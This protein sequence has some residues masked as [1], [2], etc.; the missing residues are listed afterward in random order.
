MQR[1]SLGNAWNNRV[2]RLKLGRMIII[3]ASVSAVFFPAFAQAP[4]PAAASGECLLLTV[5]GKVEIARKGEATWSPGQT[6]Q[7]LQLGDRLRTGLRSRATVR[8]SDLSV[9]RVKEVTTI[10]IQPP[11]KSADK[12]Q[13]ELK[14]GATYLFSRE[15]PTEI[16]FRTPVASGAIRGTEFNLAVGED[17]ATVVSLLNGEVELANAQGSATLKSGEQV[18]VEPGR[19]PVKTPLLN[20]LNV[21]Q[22]VLYYPAVVAPEDFGLSAQ[23]QADLKQPLRDYRGGDLLAALNHYPENRTPASDAERGFLAALLL[24]VGNVQEAEAAIQQLPADAAVAR[25]LKEVVAA[26]QHRALITLSAPATASE[27]MARSYYYQSRAELNEALAAA[28][29]AVT[30]SPDFGAAH[31]RL[32]DLEFSFGRTDAALQAL[33]RGLA[34]SPRNAQGF[35]LKGYLLCARNQFSK[36]RNAFDQAIALDGALP[37]AWLGRGLVKFRS[38]Y[39]LFKLTPGRSYQAAIEDLQVAATLAP[40]QAILRSYLG[41]G[42]T[43]AYKDQLARKDLDLAKTLDPN[44]PTSWLYS[45]LLD[46]QENQRNDAVTDLEKSKEL[47]DN[48]SIFR[49][50]FLLDQDQAVRG[51][52]L[53]SMYRDVGMTDISVQE[54]ARAVNQDYGNFAAH[55]FLSSSYD[56]LRDPNLI[57][58]RYETPWYSQLLVADLLAPVGGGNLS[59]TIS[60]QE[61]SRLFVTD[62]T[63]LFS[64]TEYFSNGSWQQ[65]GSVYGLYGTTSYAVDGFYRFE[66][67]QRTNGSLQQVEIDA[68]VKEQITEKDSVFLQVGYFKNETGDVGQYY[69]QTNASQTL[70]VTEEQNP[71]LLLGYHREWAPGSHTLFLFTRFDDTLTLNDSNPALLYLRTAVS[72]FTGNTNVSLQN[73]A[74]FS[75]DYQRDTIA[76]ST[77]LQQIWQ[78]RT[79]GLIAGARCQWAD[80]QTTNQVLRTPP[81][82]AP[83]PVAANI[84]SSLDR[85]AVYGY[86]QWRPLDSLSLIAGLSYDY[87]E[88]PENIDTA[89]ITSAETSTDQISPKAGI[90]WSPF[91]STNLRAAYA[92]SQGGAFLDNS[93]TLEPT[94]IA[95]FN[96]SFR[97]LI[98][99]SVAGLV[100]GTEFNMFGVGMDQS[101]KTHTYFYVQAEY[102]TSDGD[103]SVGILTNSNPFVPIANSAGS[104]GQ[105]LD[106]TEKALV[107]ALNQL[108]GK[109]FSLGV[110]YK[111]TDADLNTEA[112]D[113][114]KTVPGVAALTQD[115]GATLNQVWLYGIYQNPCGFFA[116]MDA[117]WSSQSNRGYTPALPGDEFW[118]YNAF[119]GYRFLQ[120]R[121][122]ARVGL[123]NIGDQDYQLNPLTLYNELPRSRTLTVNLKINF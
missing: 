83:T 25:A 10:E 107:V 103:R 20:A 66:N 113:I 58:L 92:R 9:L 4:P 93:V 39:N 12:P 76:Y 75:M 65:S 82:G 37:N 70:K 7:A 14:S 112:L 43:E 71:N 5:E 53:A 28:R 47:N 117:I 15:K 69:Y 100:P 81:L 27:W 85:V 55:L 44:D 90:L 88:Y 26:V 72:P 30:K 29:Q 51:A 119:I 36:A 11:A 94:E 13:L 63:D 62:G 106:F 6:N 78:N 115:V 116:Q 86:G 118:Q 111:L 114:A 41:K 49:S 123:L 89:P 104:T 42:F 45:S 54:A 48:R 60:Q 80:M 73:P 1:F 38:S 74:F 102:L 46:Q 34:L 122:E 16:Q 61:Y 96:Q 79:F 67:A 95:G 22:W 3:L 21:I 32:A 50:T 120:R 8:W 40:Q 109:Q 19:A 91:K 68:R 77:E 64:N 121:I 2:G 56:A 108:I 33:D 87:L 23:E 31:I 24:S 84:A 57:N 97:S 59:Q 52:N 110:R 18:T 99:E 98:P 17:G 35:A 101:F 105:S